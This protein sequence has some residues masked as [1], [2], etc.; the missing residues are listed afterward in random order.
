MSRRKNQGRHTADTPSW[1]AT[2]QAKQIVEMRDLVIALGTG[3]PLVLSM[4]SE[5]LKGAL[6]RFIDVARGNGVPDPIAAAI[7]WSGHHELYATGLSDAAISAACSTE[8]QD[9][10]DSLDAAEQYIVSPQ[11]HATTIAAAYTLTDEDPY[12]IHYDDLPAETGVVMFP[13]HMIVEPVDNGVPQDLIA[14]SWS[15]EPHTING[16][17]VR[18]LIIRSWLDTYGPVEVEGF[19]AIQQMAKQLGAP[20]PPWTKLGRTGQALVDDVEGGE[21]PLD[22]YWAVSREVAKPHNTLRA[23]SVEVS[24]EYE[25]DAAISGQ[26]VH[27]WVRKYLFAF[28]RLADQKIATAAPF[29]DGI[30]QGMKHQSHHDTR[31]VQLR[32]PKSARSETAD[33]PTRRHTHRFVVRIH[34]AN[35]WYPSLGRHKVIWRGPYIKG[36]EGAPMMKGPRVNALTR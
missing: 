10:L 19:T 2:K 32:A 1:S 20:L 13:T 16:T 24:A 11:M 12:R 36:P 29:R 27:V 7:D 28:F 34:R 21:I 35:Q 15:I 3:N 5:D 25:S 23:D 8:W 9:T 33:E 26:D 31:V 14:I 22:D 4:A 6:G 30:Y 18:L 17:A